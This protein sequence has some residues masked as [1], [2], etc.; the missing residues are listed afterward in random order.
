MSASVV[1]DLCRLALADTPGV[2][3]MLRAYM[4][5]P[6]THDGSPAVSVGAFFGTPRVWKKWT[7][8]WNVAKRP[9]KVYH[10]TDLES[11]RREFEGW[12]EDQ[13]SELVKKLLPVIVD[14]EIRGI[15]I[16]IHMAAFSS[17]MKDR[18]DLREIFPSPYAACFQWAIQMLLDF[19]RQVGNREKLAIVHEVNDFRGE[20]D[21][22]FNVLQKYYD[23]DRT[24]ARAVQFAAKEE[25]VPLQAADILAFES[26]KRF[27]DSSR[28]ERR[29][30]QM[31]RPKI[32]AAQY[33]VNNMHKL[34]A[35]LDGLLR[36][37][38]EGGIS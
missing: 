37:R 14:A 24:L 25:Q 11:G 7:V 3:A 6:G 22:A 5:E 32:F 8:A 27:R 26:N 15:V 19:K 36:L 28:P 21:A 17:A 12:T 18:P 20:I 4:D 30:W 35:N 2:V 38:M 29:P 34:I 31:M 33:G 13:K 1:Y 10:A 16:G 9:I 23:P